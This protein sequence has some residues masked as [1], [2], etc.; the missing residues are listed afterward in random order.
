[1]AKLKIALENKGLTLF[2]GTAAVNRSG[3]YRH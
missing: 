2:T 1:M 3:E